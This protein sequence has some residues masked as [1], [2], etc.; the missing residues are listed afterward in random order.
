MEPTS[1]DFTEES[2]KAA[3]DCTSLW[4][5]DAANVGTASENRTENA[6]ISAANLRIC[7]IF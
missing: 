4:T 7:F 6:R 2:I 1:G 5:L 3:L